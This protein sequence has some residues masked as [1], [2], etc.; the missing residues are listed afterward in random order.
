MENMR[1]EKINGC[2]WCG[3]SAEGRVEASC[4][5]IK[6]VNAASSYEEAFLAYQ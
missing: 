4:M 2:V 5:K 1:E 3:L 6:K